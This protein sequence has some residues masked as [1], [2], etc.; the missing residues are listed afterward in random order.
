MK[1]DIYGTL[2][3]DVSKIIK[4]HLSEAEEAKTDV[5]IAADALIADLKKSKKPLDVAIGLMKI[6]SKGI[7]KKI[8][9]KDVSYDKLIPELESRLKERSVNDNYKIRRRR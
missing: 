9:Y 7:E 5:E 4:K 1:N 3:K 8:T 2:M 6:I